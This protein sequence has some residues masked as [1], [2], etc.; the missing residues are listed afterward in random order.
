VE[1]SFQPT[2]NEPETNRK[3]PG[4]PKAT[5]PELSNDVTQPE[6]RRPR[7]GV[8]RRLRESKGWSQQALADKAVVSFKTISSMDRGNRAQLSS[9]GKVAKALGV[10]PSELMESDA[11][12]TSP[13]A[14]ASLKALEADYKA[15]RANAEPTQR[16]DDTSRA[17]ACII[18]AT[19]ESRRLTK[20]LVLDQLCT[21]VPLR[22]EVV[23]G[24]SRSDSFPTAPDGGLLI[25]MT[26]SH[27]ALS[28]TFSIL[29]WPN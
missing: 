21:L 22:D 17:K 27:P 28:G 13:N 5:C 16:T 6:K 8:I 7:K 23:P 18:V 9:F 29:R 3:R 12:E 2:G 20:K 26:L 14:L 11:P 4:V 1:G 25:N 19:T 24:T 10:E 15:L